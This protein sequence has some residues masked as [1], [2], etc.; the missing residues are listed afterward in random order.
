MV[1][2][3]PGFPPR[4]RRFVKFAGVWMP[5]EGPKPASAFLTSDQCIGCHDA[6]GTGLQYD[7]TEPGPGDKLINMSPYA[8]WRRSVTGLAAL[9]ASP[10]VQLM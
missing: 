1:G 5:A 3:E 2:A 6:H 9:V 10:V 7:M 8:T 4:Q